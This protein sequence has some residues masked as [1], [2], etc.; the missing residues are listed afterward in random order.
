MNA[1]EQ[2]AIQQAVDALESVCKASLMA[3]FRPD[4]TAPLVSECR[5][6]LAD[7]RALGDG[8]EEIAT[9]PKD[10]TDIIGCAYVDHGFGGISKSGPWTIAFVD[11][12]WVCSC[13][14]DVVIEES[15]YVTVYKRPDL[16][17]THWQPLPLPPGG[18]R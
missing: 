5:A 6:A 10:G 12:E 8:W 16:D 2:A 1:K 4:S 13:G 14:G 15:M 17:P 3:G 18:G 7:L 11:G 9:A